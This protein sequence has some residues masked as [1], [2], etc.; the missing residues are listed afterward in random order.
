MDL[1]H[2]HPNFRHVVSLSNQERINFLHAPRWIGYPLA[3]NIIE[4]M[5]CLMNRPTKP[6]MDNLLLV[7]EPANGKTTI[8]N[9]F[10]ELYAESSLDENSQPYKP[11]ISTDAPETA[12]IK[13][14]YISILE[15]FNAP[16]RPTHHSSK[17]LYQVIYLMRHCNVKILIIDEF[18]SLLAGSAL[19]QREVMNAIKKLC[20]E[21]KIPIIA[22]GT[23]DALRILHTD[24]QHA[25]RFDSV[26]LN[27]WNLDKEFQMLLADFEKIIP[28]SKPSKLH[29]SKKATLLHT[30]SGGNLGNL[31]KLLIHCATD[32]INNGEEHISL[33]ML[34][35]KRWFKPGRAGV[36]EIRV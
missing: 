23:S 31:H 34:N 7:G 21:L 33:N 15:K 22:S 36:R 25:S 4:R 17:L 24:P 29:T 10:V 26:T 8:I 20:N 13:G 12:D 3:N 32:A 19:K 9:R 5:Y 27:K 16:Y 6:R 18:H 2:L 11:V 1:S 14:L 30:L 28:L 35:D